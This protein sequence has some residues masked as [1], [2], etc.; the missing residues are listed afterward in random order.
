M[1]NHQR[2]LLEQRLAELGKDERDALSRR[3]AALRR[4][5]QTRKR[6]SHKRETRA[7][8]NDHFEPDEGGGGA[9]GK[10]RIDPV[11]D[12]VLRL[13]AQDE[14]ERAAAAAERTNAPVGAGESGGGGSGGGGGVRT[15]VA[16]YVGKR[17]CIVRPDDA[18]RA[19]GPDDAAGDVHCRLPAEMAGRQQAGLCVGDRV[20]FVERTDPG[21]GAPFELTQVLPRR[22]VLVRRDPRTGQRRAIV[23]NVDVVAIVVSVVRP[24]LHPRLIDRYL[25][26]IEDS[27]VERAEGPHADDPDPARPIIC[28]NKVDLLDELPADERAAELAKL[29]PYER[30]GIP[31]IRCSTVSERGIDELRR[32]LAGKTVAFVGHSGVGKSS[33]TNALDPRIAAKVGEVSAAYHKGRHTTTTAQLYD[34]PNPN[35]NPHP[36]PHPRPNP[37]P[38]SDPA[39][40]DLEPIRVIDTPGI[41]SFALESMTP[42]ELRDA[43]PEFRALRRGCR[44]NDCTHTHEPGCAV[45]EAVGVERG[46]IHPARYETYRRML[47]E[48]DPEAPGALDPDA[49]ERI[50]PYAEEPGRKPD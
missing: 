13:L 49:R 38:A 1:N 47:A 34:V 14:A 35:P 46:G 15:G 48:I 20:A 31:V 50:R 5:E 4:E 3:A 37:A 16:V 2:K 42:A 26:A 25:I 39:Y 41:R 21:E 32:V 6:I 7:G 36:H 10:R 9:R 8:L 23:A 24:P 19:F 44:F 17:R 27:S 30:L 29:E 43:F 45:R 12:Y 28:L 22:T 33:L 11:R 18:P 40:G